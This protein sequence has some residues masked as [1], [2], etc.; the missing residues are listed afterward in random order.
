MTKAVRGYL[1]TLDGWR[2]IAVLC[3]ILFHDSL[4]S[5][6]VLSTAWF[7]EHGSF[8]VDIFFGI[9]GLLICSRLLEEEDK[10]GRISLRRFYVRRAFRILPPLLCSS[11]DCSQC[12]A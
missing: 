3:V 12:W 9:S 10:Y 7:H 2:A 1:P 4:H 11:P 6:G 5:Y 8:G